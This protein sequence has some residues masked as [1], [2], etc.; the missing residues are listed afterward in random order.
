MDFAA[1]FETWKNVLTQPGEPVFEQE[2]AKPTATLQTALIWIVVAAVI[3]AI[4]S[5]ISALISSFFN[6]GS[7]FLSSD[8]PPEAAAIMG[9]V[10]GGTAFGAFCFT[11]IGAPIGFL[12]GSGIYMLIAK[13]LGGTGTFEEQTYLLATF[14]A[15]IMIVNSVISVVPI[16]G[17]CVSIFITI[18]QLVLTYYAIKVSHGMESGR[19]IATVLIPIV[20]VFLCVACGVVA[21]MATAGAAVFEGLNSGGF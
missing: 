11:L 14:T 7:A 16:L 13:L 1:M 18:Y 19:A 6:V 5:A 15:P 9:G 12:I 10:G 3:A 21:I 17:G 20:I 8:L 2:R 4:F